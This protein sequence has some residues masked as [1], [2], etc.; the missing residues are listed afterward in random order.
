MNQH[1]GH[2]LV[3]RVLAIGVTMYVH[4]LHAVDLM[5]DFV[6]KCVFCDNYIDRVFPMIVCLWTWTP[7]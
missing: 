6:L 3:M 2:L 7:L 1:L 5:Y 4:S